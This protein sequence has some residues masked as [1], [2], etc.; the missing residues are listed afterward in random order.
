MNKKLLG[1][2]LLTSTTGIATLGLLNSN[3]LTAFADTSGTKYQM[4][5]DYTNANGV[6][7]AINKNFYEFNLAGETV[8]SKY[9][10]GINNCSVT[11][12]H[13]DCAKV[14][15][16][17]DSDKTFIFA[18]TSSGNT[19]SFKMEVYVVSPTDAPYVTLSGLFAKDGNSLGTFEELHFRDYTM[20][21][22]YYVFNCDL[23]NTYSSMYL[24]DVR[25]TY[26]C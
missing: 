16:Y 1:I 12:D 13:V 25:V 10:F 26:Y 21:D 5:F 9:D 15:K 3:T 17:K 23:D 24:F 22:N 8:L 11:A 4:Y 19:I 7:D 18:A 14:Y 6:Y 20:D 2:L